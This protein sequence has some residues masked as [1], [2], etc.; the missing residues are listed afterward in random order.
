[1]W[2]SK[3]V[4]ARSTAPEDAAAATVSIG[5][6]NPAVITDAER[7]QARLFSPG[8]YCWRPVGGDTVLVVGGGEPY[9]AGRE[10]QCPVELLPG[11]VYL[12]SAGA[13]VW[14]K[15]SGDVI[16]SGK[17]IVKDGVQVSGGLTVDGVSVT[18]GV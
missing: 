12:Y 5:G 4:A 14:L 13:S 6:E 10:Q 7:R 2:L 8:G 17:L 11:E 15:N 1:M 3:Q 9:V 16:I 18:G